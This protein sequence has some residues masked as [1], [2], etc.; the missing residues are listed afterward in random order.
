MKKILVVQSSARQDGSLTRE[1]TAQ[2][3]NQIQAANPGS[4]VVTRDL[5]AEPVPHLDSSLLG[6]WMKPTDEQTDAEKDA[7]ARSD[8][9]IDELLA[10]DIVVIGSSMYNFG[11]ASTLK[12]W[13]DHVLR[14]GRTFKYTENGPVGLTEDRKVY[15]VTARGGRYAGTSIDFQEPYVRQLLGFIG[16]KDVEFINVEG[17][18]LGPEEAAKGRAEAEEVLAAIA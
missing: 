4:W 14:A 1:Y 7:A 8:I 13:F 6:G 12:S 11:I 9:L 15:V 2:L 18:A 3:V 10:S 17:Q 5:G 16:I